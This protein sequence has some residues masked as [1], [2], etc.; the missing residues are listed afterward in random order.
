MSNEPNNLTYER[1][2]VIN[3]LYD[4]GMEY[5]EAVEKVSKMADRE[6]FRILDSIP[7]EGHEDE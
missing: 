3:Y 2:E 5:D 4:S 7:E 1:K 6:V